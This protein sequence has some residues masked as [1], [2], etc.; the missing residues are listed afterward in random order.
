[1][2]LAGEIYVRCDELSCRG[3]EDRYAQEGLMLKRADTMEWIY[4][5]DWRK[6]NA[7]AGPRAF[8]RDFLG[9]RA[10]LGRLWRA[11]VCRDRDAGSFVRTRIKVMLERRVERKARRLLGRSGLLVT[12]S[13]DV[14]HVVRDGAEFVHPS[15]SGE[16]I[17]S[18]GSTRRLMEHAPDENY[19]GVVFIGPF[20]CMP[21]GIAESVV[22]PYARRVGIP[23]VTFE[24]DAGPIPPNLRS[25]VEVHLLRARR[26]HASRQ[27]AAA[28]S[29]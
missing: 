13:H 10:F 12:A 23:Y 17:L 11:L 8:P 19:C 18:A 25:Q 29:G 5:T 26:Y 21:T 27:K 14:D 4:Y 24:T 1:V 3:L 20:N 9:G 28:G 2:L 16:A 22:K 6:L 7:L 15:L